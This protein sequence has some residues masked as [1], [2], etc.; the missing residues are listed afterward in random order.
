MNPSL[1]NERSDPNAQLRR[2]IYLILIVVTAGICAGRILGAQ[3]VYEPALHRPADRPD[4]PGRAWPKDPPRAMPTFSSNDRARWATIRALVD[5]G[6]YVVGRRDPK[7][8]TEKNKYGDT[9]IVFEDGW[10]TVD[11]VLHPQRQE[12]YSSKPPLL[13]TLLA[14]EYWLLQ[15][16][17]GWTL[18]T[19]PWEVVRTVLFT[20]NWIPLLV[21]LHLLSRLVDRLS[22]SDWARVFAVAAACFGTFLTTF[23]TTLNNH[24]V[25]AFGV[26]FALYPCLPLWNENRRDLWRFVLAGLFAAWAA[27]NELPAA[28]FAAGLFVALFFLAP[29]RTLIGFTLG[30]L[31]P[32][33]LFLLTNYVAV[34]SLTPVQADFGSEWYAYE[35]SHWLNIQ[36]NPRGIDAAA[37]PL[38]MYLFHL[39]LGHHGFLALTPVFFLSMAGMVRTARGPDR[40]ARMLAWLTALVSVVVLAFYLWK[41]NNY[42]GWT[43]GPRWFFWLIPLWLLTL[44]PGVE[45]LA[46]WRWGRGLALAL[47]GLSALHAAYPAWNPWRHPSLFNLLEYLQL[48]Q[49]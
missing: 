21:Y 14:G 45:W 8:I 47:L 29:L 10:G 38:P 48:I 49:Y 41:T 16:L 12:F 5:E 32:I 34:G 28:A 31:P 19:H 3:L 46:R 35:G 43:S 17:F 44:T 25:A 15:K 23:I 2:S 33:V 4:L 7:D 36:R 18:T 27:C 42:G 9:G 40:F 11:K 39:L 37:D 26:L 24:D 20:V 1:E 6:T 13:P 30:A 22:L